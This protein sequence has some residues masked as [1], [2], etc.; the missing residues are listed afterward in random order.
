MVGCDETFDGKPS[1]SK[2]A[3]AL[4]KCHRLDAQDEK[5]VT[6]WAGLRNHAAHGE[7]DEVSREEARIMVAGVNLFMQQ[8]STSV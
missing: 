6:A 4:R 2:Y 7:F 5:N 1:L 3:A 8:K